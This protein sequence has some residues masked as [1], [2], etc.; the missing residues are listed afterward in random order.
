MARLRLFIGLVAVAS[1]AAFATTASGAPAAGAAACVPK[2]N[3][4]AIIDDSGSML[5]T[6]PDRL[7]VQALNLLMS[8]PGNGSKTLGAIEF[9]SDANSIFAPGSIG[10][11]RTQ[12]SQLLDQQ[13]QGNNGGTNYN[14]AFDLAKTHNAGADVRIFLT[15]GGHNEGAYAEGHR[16]GPTTHAIGL[17]AGIFGE[18]EGRLKRIAQETGGIYRKATDASEIQAAMNDVNAAIN[19]QSQPIDFTDTFTRAGQSKAHALRI[20]RGT[21]SVQFALSWASSSDRFDISRF[22]IL[23]RGKVVARSAKVRRL[24][25]RKSRG[26]TFVTVKVS[27]VVRGKLRFRVQA[28]KVSS[29]TFTGVKLITQASRSRRR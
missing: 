17:S 10:A 22:L 20:P 23:R 8:V 21:R 6:D 18:D 7:R 26:A 4:E 1:T 9:G 25:V 11:N 27:R 12:F 28:R 13:V 14:A 24:R 2:A 3:A 16:G 5:G 15:D 29:S 19:C